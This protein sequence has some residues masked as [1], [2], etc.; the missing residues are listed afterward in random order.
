MLAT[1][2]LPVPLVPEVSLHLADREAGLF[3]AT[4]GDYRSDEP[5]PFWAFVWAGGQALARFLLDHPETVRGKHVLD[6]A[7]GSGVVAIAA[8]MAGAAE[9]HAI[10]AD[11]SATAAVG[12]NA[13][14]NGVE[15]YV[16]GGNGLTPTP[17][18][19][20][21]ILTYN[22]D[23]GNNLA[24]GIVISRHE[25]DYLRPVDYGEDVRIELWISQLRAASFTVAYELFDGDVLA[26]RARSV[27]V[28]YNLA[29]GFPRRLTDPER[30]F[31]KPYL[32]V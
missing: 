14:A 19:S 9:V 15:V 6:L 25:V 13:A 7:S 30:D 10:D 29:G 3:D 31:L 24:D 1:A 22:R 11:P 18:I 28:P 8:A 17:V 4:G 16:A 32:G 2:L 26:S 5:P 21:A 20:H 27:C 12:R 23:R